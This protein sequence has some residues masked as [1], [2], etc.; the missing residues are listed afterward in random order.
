MYDYKLSYAPNNTDPLSAF[1]NF[2]LNRTPWVDASGRSMLDELYVATKRQR[3][4]IQDFIIE[5]TLRK[6]IID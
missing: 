1:K 3:P 4:I 2:E 6:V 5:F